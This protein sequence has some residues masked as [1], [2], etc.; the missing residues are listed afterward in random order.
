MQQPFVLSEPMWQAQYRRMASP[1]K[2]K[3]HPAREFRSVRARGFTPQKIR[4]LD[5]A[6]E[7]LDDWM[8]S[9]PTREPP[10]E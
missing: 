6:D 5:E 7:L 9:C 2:R 4:R 3:S 1:M 8:V 10:P